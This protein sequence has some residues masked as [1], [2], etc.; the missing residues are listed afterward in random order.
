MLEAQ[1]LSP[2]FDVLDIC[3]LYAGSF[4]DST[5]QLTWKLERLKTITQKDS[6]GND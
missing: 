6:P 4:E 2:A 3:E 1:Y 5:E